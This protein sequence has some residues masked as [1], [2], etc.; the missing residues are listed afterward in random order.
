MRQTYVMFKHTSKASKLFFETPEKQNTHYE[1]RLGNNGQHFSF[2]KA[3]I[4]T[5]FLHSCSVSCVA[6]E[7]FSSFHLIK[8]LIIA[9]R[10]WATRYYNESWACYEGV[11]NGNRLSRDSSHFCEVIF[12]C[13]YQSHSWVWLC[14]YMYRLWPALYQLDKRAILVND[15]ALI[16]I[17]FNRSA[18]QWQRKKCSKHVNTFKMLSRP[19]HRA[20]ILSLLFCN[21]HNTYNRWCLKYSFLSYFWD[22]SLHFPLG[23]TAY[24]SCFIVY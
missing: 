9:K 17:P 3:D 7:N 23:Y 10:G 1:A 21:R 11:P 18:S 24:V 14:K 8:R 20:N 6:P 16:S 22:S 19:F 12:T 4:V 2:L 5:A 15:R 13:N